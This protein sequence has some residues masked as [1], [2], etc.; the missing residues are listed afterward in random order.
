MVGGATWMSPALM[1]THNVAL[2]QA[3][4]RLQGG[5]RA[6]GSGRAT[7]LCETVVDARGRSGKNWTGPAIQLEPEFGTVRSNRKT[8]H[9]IEPLQTIRPLEPA[10]F[11][12]NRTINRLR[13]DWVS[14]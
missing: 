11:V 10:S 7:M 9:A 1:R 2:H 14:E 13:S 3:W 5:V 4:P 6:C 12:M 8:G